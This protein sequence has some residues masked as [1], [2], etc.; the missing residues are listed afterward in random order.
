MLRQLARDSAVYGSAAFVSRAVSFLL[1]PVYTRVFSPSDYGTIE[2]LLVLA[3]L[4]NV[5]VALEIAQ[6]VARYFVDAGSEDRRR[7]ASTALFFAAGAYTCFALVALAFAPSIAGTLLGDTAQAGAVRIA[8]FSTWAAGL[9]YQA[10]LQLRWQLRPTRYAFASLLAAAA[11]IGSTIVFVIVLGL[12]VDGV[13]LGYLAGNLVGA[14]AAFSFL[15]DTYRL[16]FDVEKLKQMLGFSVP[17]VAS[18]VAVFLNAYVDRIAISRL[19]GLTEVGIYS[20][21][22]RLASIVGLVLIGFQTALMP[23]VYARYQ[24]RE[25]PAE[26]ARVFRLFILL[27]ISAFVCLSLFSREIV[28][29]V[30][31]RE[32]EDAAALMPLLVPAVILSAMYVFAPGPFLAKRTVMIGAINVTA[33]GFNVVLNVTLIPV[34]GLWGSAAATLASATV[35]F[36]LMM[37]ASQRMYWVPHAWQALA[38]A[39]AVA[40]VIVGA[41]AALGLLDADAWSPGPVAAKTAL[42]LLGLGVAVALLLQ[43]QERQIAIDW[44]RSFLRSLP[45]QSR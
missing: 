31:S 26:L 2:L 41:A 3:A 16:R 13:F 4:I 8:V 33:A 38:R 15:R 28:A 40:V 21:A 37:V 10:Q 27:A 35:A 7:Y 44:T 29:T 1:L 11:T 14:A 42:A 19:L 17:L 23:L 18:S 45:T 39:V 36:G 32:F 5:T 12:G 25:T 43:K 30:A 20:V 6:G 9:F 34:L 24:E 22:F